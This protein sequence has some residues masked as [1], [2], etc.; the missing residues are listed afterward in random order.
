MNT[1]MK[2]PLV[3]YDEHGVFDVLDPQLLAVVDAAPVVS[4]GGVLDG[5]CAKVW[6]LINTD[7]NNNGCGNVGCYNSD[8]E[9]FVNGVC[10]P[11]L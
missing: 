5:I 4:G 2:N 1:I 7:C 9:G 11:I 6:V 8:C 10:S 3:K